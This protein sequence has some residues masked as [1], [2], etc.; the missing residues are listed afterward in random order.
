M[1]LD[2]Y[3]ESEMPH[4]E[5]P[6]IFIRRDGSTVEISRDEWNALYPDREPI[7]TQEHET[8]IL[9]GANI[10]HNLSRMAQEAGIYQALW[11][12]EEINISKASQL[13]E[14]LENGLRLLVSDQSRFEQFNPSNNWGSYTA[15]VS[16]VAGY[17]QACKEYPNAC[18]SVSR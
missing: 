4:I 5:R 14:P 9:Y 3:L 7:E 1:S 2:V 10:T 18:V 8:T 17:L 15:L 13:I 6:G 12:P 11:R 16:F